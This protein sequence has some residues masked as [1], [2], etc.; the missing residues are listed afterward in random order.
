MHS[1]DLFETIVG[2]HYEA[3]FRFAL[4]L[5]RVESDAEDLTQ[6]TFCIWAMKRYQL[7][8]ISKV[9]S[10]LYTTM[11]RTFL[12]ARRRQSSFPCTNLDAVSD[13]LADLC[14]EPS[15]YAD[16][17]QVLLAL[18][19]VDAAYQSAV[20]LFYLED[21]SYK[22]IAE[23]LEIPVGTVKSRLSRGIAQLR[24]FLLSERRCNSSSH[25]ERTSVSTAVFEHPSGA[26]SSEISSQDEEFHSCARVLC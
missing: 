7:R 13:Q 17:S 3:L 14:P 23:I 16:G 9:K 1:V 24:E 10:W 20:A 21:R 15:D 6:Q 22:D 2:E 11:H 12:Q 5:T 18:A 19:R 26:E 8:D 25:T 4:S